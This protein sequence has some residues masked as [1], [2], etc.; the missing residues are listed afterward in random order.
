AKAL[1]TLWM[2]EQLSDWEPEL[3]PLTEA[4]DYLFPL[5]ETNRLYKFAQIP[6]V[7]ATRLFDSEGKVVIPIP[8]ILPDAQISAAD[9]AIL[10]ALKPVTHCIPAARSADLSIRAT[11]RNSK[12][13][14]PLLEIL[15]PLR[16]PGETRLLGAVQFILD[17]SSIAEEFRAMDHKLMIRGA[18]TFF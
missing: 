4:T 1:D 5:L 12:E 16:A 18:A 2:A 17:G 7:K 15:V 6:S 11:A 8:E 10:A 9:F 14:F 13:R 3:G